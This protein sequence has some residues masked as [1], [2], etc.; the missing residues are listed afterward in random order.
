MLVQT[1]VLLYHRLAEL[2]TENYGVVLW[3]GSGVFSV[4]DINYSY[5]GYNILFLS[6]YQ[7]LKLATQSDENIHWPGYNGCSDG[8]LK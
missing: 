6:P 3:K 8:S 2:I 5:S 7:K 1:Q 4:D